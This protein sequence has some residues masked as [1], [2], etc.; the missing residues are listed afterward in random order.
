MLDKSYFDTADFINYDDINILCFE[1][2]N[3][4]ILGYIPQ[5]N[6]LLDVPK[7]D[8]WSRL[9]IEINNSKSFNKETQSHLTEKNVSDLLKP[10]N[11]N[12]YVAYLLFPGC[13]N[14]KS[15]HDN[16]MNNICYE[17]WLR[18]NYNPNQHGI[19]YDGILG[20]SSAFENDIII[21]SIELINFDHKKYSLIRIESESDSIIFKD[22]TYD[23][24]NG[25]PILTNTHDVN[26]SEINDR[27]IPS[28]YF[29]KEIIDLNQNII[30]T[31]IEEI[32]VFSNFYGHETV[33]FSIKNL[34]ENTTLL[35]LI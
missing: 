4:T 18:V 1:K 25:T 15:C 9:K 31:D 22:N 7:N 28:V 10:D 17:D 24:S 20:N 8:I 34:A 19:F 32:L 21:K 12:Q 13:L 26:L 29:L 14:K 2:T 23:I 3:Y 35:D 30:T 27:S 33:K 16:E 11:D 5:N 6:L